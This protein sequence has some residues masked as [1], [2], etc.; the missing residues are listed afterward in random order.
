MRD[1]RYL[2][3]LQ[4]EL[5]WQLRDR[6]RPVQLAEVFA[7]SAGGPNSE[8]ARVNKAK[9][10]FHVAAVQAVDAAATVIPFKEP[11]QI[12]KCVRSTLAKLREINERN[13]IVS[14]EGSE[15]R[16]EQERRAQAG[17]GKARSILFPLFGT[18]QGGAR[19]S[20]VIDPIVAGIVGFFADEDD[21][22]LADTLSDVYV[23]AFKQQDVEETLEYLRKA[24]A[25]GT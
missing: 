21:G 4:G 14:P 8:L 9:F 19:A 5:D 2:D 12:E 22:I 18:G 20:E 1:N 24:L 6:G 23:S 17:D 15:Q 3:V 10:V 11:D 25:G 16:A 7:T 13:G